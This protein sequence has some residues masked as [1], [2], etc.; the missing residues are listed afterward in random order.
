MMLEDYLT[1]RLKSQDILLMT[2]IVM[3]YPSFEESLA[4]VDAMV[5]AGVDLMELQIPFSE[6]IADGPVIMQA[7]QGALANGVTVTRC[8]DFAETVTQKYDIPFLL[9]TYYNIPFKYGVNRFVAKMAAVG[10]QGTIIADLPAEHG[11]GYINAM[12]TYQMAPIFIFTPSTSD[13]RMRYLTSAAEGMIY[14]VARKGVTGAVT[15]F[16]KDLNDYLARCRQATDLPLALGFGVKAKED[17][18]Y[19]RGKADIAVIGTRM[20]ELIEQKGISA[21][22]G[23]IRGLR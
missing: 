22:E 6:P 2:H 19:L 12:A 13:E 23:F 14:C 5:S 3:G 20:I 1:N 17:I 16:S 4:I 18:V 11:T 9:M 15:T 21:V 10:L 8:F 7:N